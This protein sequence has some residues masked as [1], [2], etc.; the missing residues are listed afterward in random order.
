MEAKGLTREMHWTVPDEALLSPD[1][2]PLPAAPLSGDTI[3][4]VIQKLR[5][6]KDAVTPQGVVFVL[7]CTAATNAA[8]IKPFTP[9]FNVSRGWLYLFIYFSV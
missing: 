4:Q 6:P 1:L 5:Q 3:K 8:E 2:V 9:Y 7:S